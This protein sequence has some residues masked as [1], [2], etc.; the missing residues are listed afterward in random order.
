MRLDLLVNDFT[1][2]ALRGEE[3]AVFEGHFKR[4]YI[5]VLDV[6]SAFLHAISN[7]QTMRG[8]IYNVGLS[9]ANLSKLELCEI[10]KKHIPKFN[11]RE[12]FNGKDPDQRNYIVSNDKIEATGYAPRFTISDGVSELIRAYPMLDNSKMRNI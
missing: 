1:C 6:V 4:N 12:D 2:R 11:Y 9:S 7:F 3:V 10:I 8:Q 5:H